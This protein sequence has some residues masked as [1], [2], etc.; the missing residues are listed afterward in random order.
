MKFKLLYIYRA[1]IKWANNF[2]NVRWIGVTWNCK[3]RLSV[4]LH[5]FL[6]WLLHCLTICYTISFPYLFSKKGIQCLAVVKCSY[7]K[8]AKVFCV[9]DCLA[10]MFKLFNDLHKNTFYNKQGV[11]FTNLVLFVWGFSSHSRIFHSYI[12][13]TLTGEWHHG[14][15]ALRVL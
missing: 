13:V 11:L 14:H 12:D 6:L 7:N 3:L 5:C 8:N 4:Y 10:N 2:Q 15:W 9:L 1:A